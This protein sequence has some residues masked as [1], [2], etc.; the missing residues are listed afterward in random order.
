MTSPAYTGERAPLPESV[1]RPQSGR[2]LVIVP[3]SDDD[4]IGCGGTV[5]LHV[6]QGD[7]V[8]I[9]VVFDGEAGD[10]D[11][12][13]DPEDLKR[14]RQA[15]ARAGGAHLGVE[16]YEF[17]GF[18]EGHEPGPGE[19][20]AAARRV[21]AAVDEVRPDIV[22]APWIG[23][24]HV[25]H[26]VVA[27]AVRMGLALAGFGGAA[28]GFEVW[29]PLVA[30]LIVDVTPVYEKKVAALK[31]HRSQL[32]YTDHVH[33]AL[34]MNA[35]RSLYLSKDAL[36]GEAFAPLGPPSDAERELLRDA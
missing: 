29:T 33:K 24:H 16:D 19:L 27:R 34:G 3:H 10:P 35:Q 7:P 30:E 22:Y 17:W 13:H 6:E 2:V 1:D 9:V 5:C 11:R 28:W 36:Y 18:S 20:V 8:R 26:H 15:E 31:E 23:E 32:A 12:H 21:S 4:V 25:D 14:V